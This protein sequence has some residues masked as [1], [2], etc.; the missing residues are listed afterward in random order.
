[1]MPTTHLTAEHCV[2]KWDATVGESPLWHVGE[3]RL[4][5]VDIQ[6]QKIHRFDPHTSKNETFDLPEIVTCLAFRH[7][8]GLL[9]TLKK[10]LAYFDLETGKLDRLAEI[11]TDLP[12]N[13]FNDG[14]C[15]RNG[16]FWAGTM[17]AKDW[18]APV[19]NLYRIGSDLSV[20][21]MQSEVKCSNG[22]DWSPDGRTMYYT[23][24]FRHAIFA[25]D[26]DP[27]TGDI[28]NRRVFA[29]VDPN[30]GCFPDGLTVDSAGFVWSNHVGAG[31]IVRYDPAGKMDRILQL[32]VP[33][34][35]GCTFGGENLDLLYITTARE[36][37]TPEQIRQAP[38]SGSLFGF[39]TDV[40][41]I[42]ATFF[43][44]TS[45]N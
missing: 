8:G 24:S 27:A 1:M 10:N 42:A 44:Q 25:Y 12:G 22:T 30:S 5:W 15:D 21:L 33:R 38:L 36:T 40:R 9:L 31:Q 32:P 35:T 41:G 6:G 20:T 2:L 28:A 34:A 13:R 7:E 3:R 29:T 43:K 26:F 45:R 17:G 37:M 16:R 39:Q 14:R 19:G 23:E 18:K 11:E 4:Y